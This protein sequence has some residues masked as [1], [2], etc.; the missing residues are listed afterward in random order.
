M[1]TF[2]VYQVRY[3]SEVADSHL[4]LTVKW[5]KQ[6]RGDTVR[7]RLVGREFASGDAR[8]DLYTAASTSN[9]ERIVD[10]LACSW[11]KDKMIIDAKNAYFHADEDELVYVTP[12]PEWIDRYLQNPAVASMA[13]DMETRQRS[14]RQ[15]S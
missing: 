7:M 4:G 2:N 6:I 12:P 1:K 3:R 13:C 10:I 15:A 9:T 8:E 5:V 11:L 14:E